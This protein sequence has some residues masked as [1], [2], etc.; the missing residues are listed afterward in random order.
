MIHSL[1][2]DTLPLTSTQIKSETLKDKRLVNDQINSKQLDKISGDIKPDYNELTVEDGVLLLWLRVILLEKLKNKVLKKLHKNHPGILRMKSLSRID[3]WFGFQTL[4]IKLR[5]LSSHAKI[6]K[7]F[8]VNQTSDNLTQGT[9]KQT[10]QIEY[11]QTISSI[12]KTIF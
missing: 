7:K 6:M 2:I 10:Q 4:I 5:A 1:Q 11:T 3:T 9:G 12:T 8:P